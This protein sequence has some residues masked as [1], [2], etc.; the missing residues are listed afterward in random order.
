MNLACHYNPFSDLLTHKEQQTN[1]K[2][3]Q[4]KLNK[5]KNIHIDSNPMGMDQCDTKAGCECLW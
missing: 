1:K 4:N 3:T 5:K 2:Q